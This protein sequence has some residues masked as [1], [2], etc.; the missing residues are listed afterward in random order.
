MTVR[1]GI[2]GCGSVSKS[3]LEALGRQPDAETVA[4]AD[5]RPEMAQKR[6]DEFGIPHVYSDATSL[7]DREDLDLVI[8]CV[9]PKWHADLMLEAVAR[10]VHVL[11]EKPLA[12]DLAEADRMVDAAAGSGRITGIALIH[13]YLPVY[14]VLQGLV[15]AGA[16]GEVRLLRLSL[17]HDTYWQ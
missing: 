16:V 15:E 10:D 3:H 5:V 13:R 14:P 6:A 7:L 11:T 9:P 4:C 8:V 1:V 12:M 2:I 17:G